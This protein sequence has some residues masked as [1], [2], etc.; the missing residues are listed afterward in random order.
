MNVTIPSRNSKIYCIS[1]TVRFAVAAVFFQHGHNLLYSV[2]LIII[3][4][5]KC[6]R[7]NKKIL[8]KKLLLLKGRFNGRQLGVRISLTLEQNDC[9]LRF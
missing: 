7:S 4:F 9:I 6:S 8:T 1:I 3:R 2:I 5:V